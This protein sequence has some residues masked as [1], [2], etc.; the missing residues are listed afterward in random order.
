MGKNIPETKD[1]SSDEI[2]EQSNFGESIKKALENS[3]LTQVEAKGLLDSYEEQK[4]GIIHYNKEQL[5]SLQRALG[6]SGN[7][8]LFKNEEL[9][10]LKLKAEEPLIIEPIKTETTMRLS[11]TDELI[12]QAE[13]MNIFQEID[14]DWTQMDNPEYKN[15]RSEEV[16]KLFS[17]KMKELESEFMPHVMEIFSSYFGPEKDHKGMNDAVNTF[18]NTFKQYDINGD[19]ETSTGELLHG[20]GLIDEDDITTYQKL[21]KSLIENFKSTDIQNKLMAILGG[22]KKSINI[23]KSFEKELPDT[24]VQ[25]KKIVKFLINAVAKYNNI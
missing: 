7:N 17:S 25:F 12:A 20:I 18:L 24:A 2:K 8:E 1:Y 11:S 3:V 23:F 5:S 6:V 14:L 9:K 10:A 22:S 15:E 4:Y 19:N 21:E 16:I 13:S